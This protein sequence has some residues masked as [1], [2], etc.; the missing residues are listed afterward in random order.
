M[1]DNTLDNTNDFQLYN[2]ENAP[3][4]SKPLIS[5]L[6]TKLGFAPNVACK[7]AEAPVVL[8]SY[9]KLN[10]I[11]AKN[12][13][14][15]PQEQ[16]LIFLIISRENQCDY[17]VAAHSLNAKYTTLD[18]DVINAVREYKELPNAKQNALADL[19]VDLV[20]SRGWPKDSSVA[21]FYEAGY[22]K[23]QLLEIVL[24]IGIKVI[25]N[26]SNH[27]VQTNLDEVFKPFSWEAKN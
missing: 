14:F 22:T 5:R 13:T 23:A 10:E 9:L 27:I 16:Q 12:G 17:C 24:A 4:E 19:T 3:E 2:V 8:E 6:I 21:A 7:M 25:S 26:Y 20:E 1:T 15:S 11:V 18:D